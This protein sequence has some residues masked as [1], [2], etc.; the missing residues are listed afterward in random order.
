MKNIQEEYQRF[1]ERVRSKAQSAIDHANTTYSQQR[2]V[3][4]ARYE[5]LSA[6]LANDFPDLANLAPSSRAIGLNMPEAQTAA[7]G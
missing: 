2:N 5:A 3:L 6:Q 4:I 1:M 7:R